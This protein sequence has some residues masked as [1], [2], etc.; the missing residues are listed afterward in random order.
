MRQQCIKEA[1]FHRSEGPGF[2]C[3]GVHLHVLILP[4]KRSDE[5]QNCDR[6]ATMG[7]MKYLGLLSLCAI[8]C[9][10]AACSSP[11]SSLPIFTGQTQAG[12]RATAAR[13]AQ[14]I[15]TGSVRD[16]QALLSPECLSSDHI[17][18]QLL[19]A[20]RSDWEGIVGVS[21][22]DIRITGVRIRD[23]TRTTA[24]AEVE[25]SIPTR[26]AGNDNWVS[27]QLIDGE[28]RVAGQCSLPIGNT[29]TT[30]F[31]TGLPRTSRTS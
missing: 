4:R 20:G 9:L 15:L 28:W 16:I 11:T 12:L 19:P 22:Q 17:T 7:T 21:F 8:T 2:R 27:Y 30:S 25:F 24:Q 29:E 1:S 14:A 31:G 23:V 18:S 5:S 26:E 6:C 3:L 13:Y 10:C